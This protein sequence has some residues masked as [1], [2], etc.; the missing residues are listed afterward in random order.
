MAITP[1]NMREVQFRI[2]GESPL[3][4]NKFSAKA[5]AQMIATQEAGQTAKSRKKREPKDFTQIGHDA[6][7]VS[8]EGWDGIHAAAFR[9]AAISACRAAGFV[10]TKAKLAIFVVAD[11]LDRDDMT[12][13]VR[14]TKG[15]PTI[16]TS[17]C[18]N[19]T[20]VIDLRPRPHYFPWEAVLRIRHDADVLTVTD[21]ANLIARVGAQVG[22]GEGRPDSKASAGQGNGLFTLAEV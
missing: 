17:S 1:P 18:R 7:H 19:A 11:G 9:N 4:I 5:R 8:T 12:P 22:I 2:V 14:L 21:V 16:I 6:R 13:L 3:V 15:E 10:M 20:G